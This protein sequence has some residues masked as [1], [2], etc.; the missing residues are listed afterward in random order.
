MSDPDRK[1]T[2]LFADLIGASSLREGASGGLAQ[3]AI[4][5]CLDKLR[6]AAGSCG[7]RVIKGTGDKVMVLIATP[8]AAADCAVA[9]HTV[10]DKMP[11]VGNTKL[12]LGIGFHY[13]PVIQRSNEVFGDTVN[14]ASRLVEQAANRQILT[15]EETA[16]SL[17]PLYRPWMRRL[18]AVEIKGRSGAVG[19]CEL[20]WRTDDSATLYAEKRSQERPAQ[21]VLTLKYR[22]H[23]LV[24]RREKDAIAIGRDDN[25]GLVIYEDQASRQHCT[26]ERR[27]DKFVLADVSS[28]GTYVTVDGEAEVLLQREEFTLRKHGFIAFGQP[29]V[30]AKELVEFFC[31]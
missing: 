25:C 29:R 18:G 27:Q 26:I 20:V 30:A 6:Q 4:A 11:A 22:D 23:K 21:A 16:E 2:V 15:T 5:G 1:T 8:D 14:L 19:L 31:D 13:G 3:Q 10:M 24:R 9:M 12:A 28:N 17:S 7:G